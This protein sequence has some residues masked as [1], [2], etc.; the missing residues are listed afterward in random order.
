M[1]KSLSLLFSVI[2]A[3]ALIGC[4]KTPLTEDQKVFAGKWVAVD[5]TFVTIYLDGGGDLKTSNSNVTGGGTTITADTVTIG[6][7][8]IKKTMKITQKPKQV[9]GTW[10]MSLDGIQ[11]IKQ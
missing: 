7:G 4:K 8:P 1:K 6:M 2:I 11:Y 3:A 10:S 5:S 9:G